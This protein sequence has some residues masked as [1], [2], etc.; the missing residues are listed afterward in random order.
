M[1]GFLFLL[2]AGLNSLA[3]LPSWPALLTP[4][5]AGLIFAARLALGP[6]SAGCLGA[7]LGWAAEPF[8]ARRFLWS[9]AAGAALLPGLSRLAVPG[10]LSGD[11][12]T[13]A[14]ALIAL[15][16]GAM[17][18]AWRDESG[19]GFISGLAG[20]LAVWLAPQ[21]LPLALLIYPVLGLRWLESRNGLVLMATAAGLFDVLCLALLISTPP[22][23]Y[24]T[25]ALTRL[26]WV[27]VLLA[28]LLLATSGI[29]TWLQNR[30]RRGRGPLGLA[31]LVLLPA[32][33][34]AVFPQ[35][36][37]LPLA[38]P[39]PSGNLAALLFPAACALAYALWR[40]WRRPR[41]WAD[42]PSLLAP[43]LLGPPKHGRALWLYLAVCAM[44][45]LV[46]TPR[47]ALCAAVGALGAAGL[48]PVALSAA[49]QVWGQ[50]PSLAIMV[51]LGLL[52]LVLAVPA[53]LAA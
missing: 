20:G 4:P 27:H 17:I 36:L 35:A 26:S 5:H 25:L 31:L 46:L 23:G 52:A 24:A 45:A 19:F 40:A 22:S 41:P 2:A 21:T 14:L 10:L 47:A 32:G 34:F 30:L 13:L 49:S 8:A 12:L 3:W 6:V 7:A 44:L 9:A 33:W 29:L 37:L 50:R 42:T 53:W 51:R 16:A 1:F 38:G 39:R 11:V 18:R 28:L 15:S 48:L 43:S